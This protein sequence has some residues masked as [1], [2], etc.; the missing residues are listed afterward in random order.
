VSSHNGE[1]TL[2][3]ASNSLDWSIP[4]ISTEESS[5]SLE[6][7]ATGDESSFFP[8]RVAFTGVGSLAGI[9][10]SGVTFVEGGSEAPFSHEAT[11]AAK[12]YTVV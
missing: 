3:S 8:V 4:L 6:F 7:S 9:S 2:N 12:D 10:I 1:W 5:G 11:V